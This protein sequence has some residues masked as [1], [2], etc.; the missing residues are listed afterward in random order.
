MT[1]GA[2]T[3]GR[4]LGDLLREQDELLREGFD[5]TAFEAIEAGSEY[6]NR[7][8]RTLDEVLAERAN[9]GTPE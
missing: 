3:L 7:K 2:M 1:E 8:R 6:L 9:K 5:E 4:R